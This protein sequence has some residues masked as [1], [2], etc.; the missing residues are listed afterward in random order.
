MFCLRGRITF[1]QKMIG[2]LKR[3]VIQ[4]VLFGSCIVRIGVIG[5][6]NS[7]DG[8]GEG[9]LEVDAS[10]VTGDVG[11]KDSRLVSWPEKCTVI[12]F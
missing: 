11:I 1:G 5:T 10:L 9:A 2:E 4:G 3:P 7:L 8:D 12:S 6:L